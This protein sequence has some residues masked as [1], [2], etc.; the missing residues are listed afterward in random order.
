[1]RAEGE[2]TRFCPLLDLRGA[3]IGFLSRGGGG[4]CRRHLCDHERKENY[5][6]CRKLE[7]AERQARH[8]TILFTARSFIDFIGKDPRGN[9]V[10]GDPRREGI[11]PRA[12][13]V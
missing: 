9:L 5:R 3:D 7:L 11:P 10:L 12:M 6:T 8:V 4:R 1:M 2:K 13:C